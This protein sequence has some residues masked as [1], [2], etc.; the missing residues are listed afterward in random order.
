MTVLL[1][2][3][4][5]T[6]LKWSVLEEPDNPHTIVHR[7][8]ENFREELCNTWL[9]LKPRYIFGCTVAAPSIAFMLTTFFHEHHFH[10]RWAG[11]E[12][13]FQGPDYTVKNGYANFR[14]LG[15]DRWYAAVGAASLGEE[16]SMVV[17]HTGTA[18]TVDSVCFDPETRTYLYRGGRIAPGPT[19][20]INALKRELPSLPT[21]LGTYQDFPRSTGEAIKTGIIDSQVGM[22]LRARDAMRHH[23]LE[24]RVFLAGGAGRWIAPYLQESI[25]NVDL[26]HNLVL[27]GLAAHVHANK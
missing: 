19:M 10:W 27:R 21:E 14:Q 26:R 11:P 15:A 1:I 3:L 17:V 6:A 8:A 9:D 23:N 16:S 7:G 12:S 25:P 13:Q 18:T 22:I 5:N 2:D 4:G 20:M 24:P